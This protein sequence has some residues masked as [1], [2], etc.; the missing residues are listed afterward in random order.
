MPKS[1]EIGAGG[2]ASAQR[3][4]GPR[5][6]A[7]E[8]EDLIQL[9][10]QLA[11]HYRSLLQRYPGPIPDP[12]P[13]VMVKGEFIF[14]AVTESGPKRL[15]AQEQHK[16]KQA[17]ARRRDLLAIEQPFVSAW[18]PESRESASPAQKASFEWREMLDNVLRQVRQHYSKYRDA[19]RLRDLPLAKLAA[20]SG[21]GGNELLG[22][23]D[24]QIETLRVDHASYSTV[25]SPPLV[26]ATSSSADI[27]TGR[28]P[29]DKKVLDAK[30]IKAILRSWVPDGRHLELKETRRRKRHSLKEAAEACGL[31]GEGK[32]ED[33][34][35]NWETRHGPGPTNAFKV[36]E[37]MGYRIA[38]STGTD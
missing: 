11:S 6:R 3:A 5:D 16:L 35:R 30:S 8:L 36:L 31:T 2:G 21:L 19:D 4:D 13:G 7:S 18:W 29:S 37:Y 25:T 10:Q 32:R 9:H 22:M 20:N 33:T 38:P 15:P 24:H 1:P 28:A 23:I 27:A 12:H 34:Y 17:A 26:S 14:T